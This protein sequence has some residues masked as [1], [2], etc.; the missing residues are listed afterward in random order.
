MQ[1]IYTH[2][3]TG[4]NTDVTFLDN[5]LQMGKFFLNVIYSDFM[6]SDVDR[7]INIKQV[8]MIS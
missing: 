6:F 4:T 5:G 1:I 2:K 3:H 7:E 8:I